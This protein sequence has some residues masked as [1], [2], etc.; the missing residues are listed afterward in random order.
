MQTANTKDGPSHCA[1]LLSAMYS[2]VNTDTTDP[3]VIVK[4]DMANAFNEADRRTTL[5]TIAGV[6]TRDYTFGPKKGEAFETSSLH[7]KRLFGYFYAMR[8]STSRNRYFDWNDYVRHVFG[9]TGG[10]QGDPLEMIAFCMTTLHIWGRIMGQHLGE[11]AVAYADDGYFTARLSVALEILSKL[12]AGF[13]DDAGLELNIGKTQVLCKV[14]V[15]DAKA[16]AQG[17]LDDHPEWGDL[18]D[19]I[20]NDRFTKDGFIGVG[21][22]LGT[23]GFAE[24]FIKSKCQEI[25]EDVDSLDDIE[26]GFI[27]YKLLRYCQATRLQHINGHVALENQ[28]VLQQQ[29][30]DA[31]I[32]AA[33]IRKGAGSASADWTPAVHAW[34]TMVMHSPHDEGGFGVCANRVSRLGAFYSTKAR[35]VAWLGQFPAEAQDIWLNDDLAAPEDWQLPGLLQL[36]GRAGP[37]RFPGLR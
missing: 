12:R 1:N 35:F 14:D 29:H 25:I 37:R 6:A 22:P 5:D 28:N 10:A 26:D 15:A 23:P 3:V 24:A 19:L 7:L 36:P 8:T 9:T 32:V 18:Q 21:V 16:A 17:I 20:A 31:K 33:L 34:V 27:H 30:V 13:R 4:I 2:E 11:R